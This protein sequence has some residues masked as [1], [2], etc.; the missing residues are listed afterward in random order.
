MARR[1]ERITHVDD[2]LAEAFAR[3]VPQLSPDVPVPSIERLRS[4]VANP[5]AALFVSFDTGR[6]TGSATLVWYDAP[7][8]RKAWI[9]DVVVDAASRGSGA[10]EALVRAAVAHAAAVGVRQV[11][12]TSNPART[13]ARALYRKIGFE[14]I[15]TTVFALQTDAMR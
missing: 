4:V 13:A 3:L 2:T 10:G 8:G 1:I 11:E 5:C 9:E 15:A 6:I 14:E 7:S 12:L